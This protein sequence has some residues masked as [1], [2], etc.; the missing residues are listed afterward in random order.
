[1]RR[2]ILAV[3]SAVFLGLAACAGSPPS[4]PP[5]EQTSAAVATSCT[6]P[7]GFAL[8]GEDTAAPPLATGAD[9]VEVRVVRDP[10]KPQS[11]LSIRLSDEA[12]GRAER[13]SAAHVGE[14]VTIAIG[15]RTVSRPTIRDP[16]VG[17]ALLVTGES[18]AEVASMRGELCGAR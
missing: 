8:F 10:E 3:L 15:G 5:A 18:E 11:A 9:V 12:R 14:H 16:I 17:P 4:P 1:M 13:Y 7:R 6:A 2:T